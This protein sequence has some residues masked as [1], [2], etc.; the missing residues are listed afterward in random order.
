MLIL[1]FENDNVAEYEL[2]RN[3]NQASEYVLIN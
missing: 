2:C 1:P 3:F